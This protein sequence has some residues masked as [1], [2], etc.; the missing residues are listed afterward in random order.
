MGLNNQLNFCLVFVQNNGVPVTVNNFI[1]ICKSSV[2]V[3]DTQHLEL[4]FWGI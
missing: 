2:S 4:M 3:N 1:Y